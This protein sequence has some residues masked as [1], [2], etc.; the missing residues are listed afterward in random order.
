MPS[1]TKINHLALLRCRND[2]FLS[3]F[4]LVETPEELRA[5]GICKCLDSVIL[6][7][8]T[9]DELITTGSDLGT[10]SDGL[11]HVLVRVHQSK[12]FGRMAKQ[13][14]ESTRSVYTYLFSLTADQLTTL[15]VTL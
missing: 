13:K 12:S 11:C 7:G 4:P 6:S 14:L 15:M 2:Q 10:S 9:K 3:P 5:Q 8:N 1:G